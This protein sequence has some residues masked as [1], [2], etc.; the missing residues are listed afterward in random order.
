MDNWDD[1][2]ENQTHSLAMELKT[3]WS[4][5]TTGENPHSIVVKSTKLGTRLPGF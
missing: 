3:G 1:P 5:L 4:W 2:A